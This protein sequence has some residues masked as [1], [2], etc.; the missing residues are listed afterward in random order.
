MW[1][2]LWACRRLPG[3]GMRF[4]VARRACFAVNYWGTTAGVL[5]AVSRQSRACHAARG[6]VVRLLDAPASLD[7]SAKPKSAAMGGRCLVND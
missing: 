1:W 3:E 6:S 4:S 5:L 7:S 2:V